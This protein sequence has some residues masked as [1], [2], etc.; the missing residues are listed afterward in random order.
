M[1]LAQRTAL[2][3]KKPKAAKRA[4]CSELAWSAFMKRHD[5]AH[6]LMGTFDSREQTSGDRRRQLALLKRLARA[7]CR[8]GQYAV[9]ILH[10]ADGGD[11]AMLAVEHGEDALLV[12]RTL[13]G[14]VAAPF[15]PW[16][17]H[18]AFSIDTVAGHRMALTLALSRT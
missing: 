10:S 7:I 6:L 18:R 11:L 2:P 5:S 17:S 8:H 13:R 1:A 12:S 14:R 16:L 9:K 3:R 4:P 15:G